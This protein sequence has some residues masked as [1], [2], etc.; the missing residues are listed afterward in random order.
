MSRHT[1]VL[2]LP[3]YLLS[4]SGV[5][6]AQTAF[7]ARVG[8]HS[9]EVLCGSQVVLRFRT[10]PGK[11]LMRAQIV[12]RRLNEAVLRSV[13]AGDV[14]VTPAEKKSSLLLVQ[15]RPLLTVTRVDARAMNSLPAPL[16]ERWAQNVRAALS[17]PLL[18]VSD[19]SLLVAYGEHEKVTFGA[20]VSGECTAEV[21][22]A[23]I[24]S[25]QLEA[26]QKIL[27]VTGRSVGKTTVQLRCGVASAGVAVTVKKRAGRLNG[28]LVAYVTHDNVPTPLIERA[29]LNAI[30]TSAQLEPGSTLSVG[31]DASRPSETGLRVPVK[32]TGP[33]YLPLSLNTDVPLQPRPLSKLPAHV[34]VVS[35]APENVARP[36]ALREAI[37]SPQKMSRLLYH[38]KN[39]GTTPMDLVVEL[40]NLN[41]QDAE[42][43]VIEGNGGTAPDEMGVGHRAAVSF[44]TYQEDTIG[45][46]VRVP[47]EQ[48]YRLVVHCLPPQWTASGL[49][50]LCPTGS[51]PVIVRVRTVPAGGGEARLILAEPTL[52][53]QDTPDWTFPQVVKT[54]EVEYRVGGNWTFIP[55]GRVPVR[56]A[57]G[58]RSWEGNFGVT[59]AVTVRLTNPSSATTKVEFVFEPVAGAAAGTFVVG[60]RI[61]ESSV[62]KPPHEFTFHTISLAPQETRTVTFLALPESGSNYPANLVV[63]SK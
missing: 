47:A 30:L 36:I 12:A 27:K 21:A 23:S 43:G 28:D 58:K 55:F 37:L 26:E 14:R 41:E 51:L 44:M 54:V 34:L 49:L 60:E 48:T 38:H 39:V 11:R 2:F 16:A 62:I 52:R 18:T 57:D 50:E 13:R 8:H 3:L 29:A 19:S 32:M 45:Y 7:S 53:P 40:V 59:Y 56:S 42:V 46:Y 17:Q 20:T 35:N 24:A 63:R 1:C 6:I 31:L 22:D 4:L 9:G 5:G 61:I 10:P 15:D 25:A 33:D